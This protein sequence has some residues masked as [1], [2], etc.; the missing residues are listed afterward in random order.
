MKYKVQVRKGKKAW[1]TKYGFSGEIDAL[2]NASL[3]SARWY[4]AMTNIGPHWRKRLIAVKDDGTKHV[5]SYHVYPTF[6]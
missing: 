2:G 5:L 3:D 4:F 1:Q 6:A